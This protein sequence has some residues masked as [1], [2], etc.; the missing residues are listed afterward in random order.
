M[1]KEK[2]LMSQV[3]LCDVETDLN[4]QLR[5]VQM[6]VT[7]IIVTSLLC[8]SEKTSSGC[9][10]A[11]GRVLQSFRILI[12]TF[13]GPLVWTSTVTPSSAKNQEVRDHVS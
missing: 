4:T 10:T 8:F 6:C 5:A 11:F 1:K 12:R 7:K 9:P 3:I 13:S 2:D